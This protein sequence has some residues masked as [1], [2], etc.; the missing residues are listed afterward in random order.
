MS[1]PDPPRARPRPPFPI[2]AVIAPLVAAV[3]IGAIIRSPY[4][5]VF[6]ALSPI[7]AIASTWEGRRTARRDGRLDAER[8]E[9]DCV[10]VER[11]LLAAHA[12]ESA[13]A[14]EVA[15]RQDDSVVL[16]AMPG[17]SAVLR[18]RT[19]PTHDD[20]AI[21]RRLA[22]LV[23][24]AAQNPRLPLSI[25]RAPATVHGR[26]PVADRLRDYC[27]TACGTPPADGAAATI[28][29]VTGLSRLTVDLADGMRL[30]GDAVLPFAAEWR[31]AEAQRAAAD[32]P[33][34]C[35]FRSLPA[36]VGDA[37]PIG[38][39]ADGVVALDLVTEGPHVIVGGASGS[40]K[41][42]FLR[43]LALSATRSADRWRVLFVDFKG[44]ATFLDL[45]RLPASV[46]LITDLDAALAA[47]ALG[48]LQAEIRR[49]ETVLAA[50]SARDIA[51]APG[52]LTRLLIVVDEYAALVQ[53][54]PDLHAVFADLSARGRSLGM[55]LVLCTQRPGGVV[56]DQVTVNCGVRIVFRTTDAAD[57][58]ALIGQAVPGLSHAPRG[59]AVLV[60]GGQASAFQAALVAAA[61]VDRVAAETAAVVDSRADGATPWAEPL[62]AHL[63]RGDARVAVQA[64]TDPRGTP[65][66]FGV[67]DD[68]AGQQWAE[69]VWVPERDGS[70][71][72]MGCAG[73]GRSTALAA[74]A[75]AARDA[76]W[77]VARVPESLVDAVAALGTINRM[78]A[79]GRRLLVVVDGL[80][81][82]LD[83]AAHDHAS[84]LLAQLDDAARALR[85]H[86][87]ALALDLGTATASARW[88]NGRVGVRLLLRALDADDH[89]AA[90]GPRGLFDRRAPAGRG[91]WHDD[92][93]QV[94]TSDDA[95][96]DPWRGDL[97]RVPVPSPTDIVGPVAVIAAQPDQ[98]AERMRH[99]TP[100]RTVHTVAEA[101]SL[102]APKSDQVVVGHPDD[103]QRAWAL[104][105]EHRRHAHIVLDGIDVADVRALLGARV[106]APPISR[107]EVWIV[108]PGQASSPTLTRGRWP[109][110]PPA[111]AADGPL[112]EAC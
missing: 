109:D 32:P 4:V 94:F 5:L 53:H 77:A 25:P 72:V 29:R 75:V 108:A 35:A 9:R 102:P 76:G 92:A 31:H 39:S 79:S 98:V 87:G 111:D 49:R 30:A 86:G 15:W 13:A 22:G 70:L 37:L 69:A 80:A 12:A 11:Q 61:D 100:V 27:R 20:P 68:V 40:G 57:A 95:V 103:W 101:A 56:H 55:H 48:S 51:D 93:V 58:R 8:F 18:E 60:R 41:S 43:A 36:G 104:L 24:L 52:T 82:L 46:G 21:E 78:A 84:A 47:R 34:V 74:V 81:E 107:G 19:P 89:A 62:P 10:A 54:H 99:G 96:G 23:S 2:I 28:I 97:I 38:E 88:S 73:S 42:E 64:T 6:A 33:A 112:S 71:G 83:A 14:F 65:L 50:A 45:R 1:L 3:V 16:G 59:R 110:S 85:A 90:G 17:V 106:D 7:I 26:G 63:A 105:G 66:R 44:G 67:R 91:S